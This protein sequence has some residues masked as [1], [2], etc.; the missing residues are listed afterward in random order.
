MNALIRWITTHPVAANLTMIF[1]ILAGL[2]SANSITQKTFPDF[3]LDVIA[4]TVAYPGA[5]PAEI[6][7][8]IVRPIEDQLSGIEGVDELTASAVEGRGSV[9]LSLLLG[10]D[11][12]TRL[13]EVKGEIDRITVFPEDAEEPTVVQASQPERALE[14]TLHGPAAPSVLKAEAERLK[15]GLVRLPGRQLRA[16]QQR[17]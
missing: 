1:V 9:Q 8:S 15:D 4:I 10:E 13:D 7:Q 17:A 3:T 16:A 2:A 6:E 11:V 12:A 5:S 14:L